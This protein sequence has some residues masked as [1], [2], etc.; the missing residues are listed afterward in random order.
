MKRWLCF[1]VFL[2]SCGGPQKPAWDPPG[3]P[4]GLV[5][6]ADV[7]WNFEW[8]QTIEAEYPNPKQ[9]NAHETNSLEVVL[10]KQGNILTMVGL[11]PLGTRAFVARQEGVNVITEGPHNDALPF[12]PALVFLDVNRSLFV[13]I[14]TTSLPDGWHTQQSHGAQIKD[15]WK[16]GLL[17]QRELSDPVQNTT[18]RIHYSPGYKGGLAPATV[19]LMNTRFRYRLTITTLQSSAL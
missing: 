6:M 11:T 14:N 16:G 3:Q 15:L 9:P 2:C 8:R 10:Q 19:T 7:P 18:L 1:Y 13:G 5:N 17:V 4:Q 12:P